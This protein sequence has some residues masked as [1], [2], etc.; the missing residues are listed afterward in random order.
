MTEFIALTSAIVVALLLLLAWFLYDTKWKGDSD[1]V[2]SQKSRCTKQ[3][4]SGT[5]FAT[6]S[7]EAKRL[8]EFLLQI[9]DS[10]VLFTL[11]INK[12]KPKKYMGLYSVDS[13][14]ITV[15]SGWCK[16]IDG[17]KEIAIHEY[18]HHIM[19]TRVGVI[20]GEVHSERFWQVYS[21]LVAKAVEKNLYHPHNMPILIEIINKA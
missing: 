2:S 10:G 18:A 4:D 9:Y 20:K 5:R 8:K 19:H 3:V 13:Q 1:V 7:D 17:L 21:A 11:S 14:H 16:S 15:F 6:N 12:G